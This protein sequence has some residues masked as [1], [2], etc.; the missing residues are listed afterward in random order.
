MSGAILL[1]LGL[2]TILPDTDIF[3]WIRY[4]DIGLWIGLVAPWIFAR[5]KL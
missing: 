3:N 2:K 5:L 1:Y 4:A